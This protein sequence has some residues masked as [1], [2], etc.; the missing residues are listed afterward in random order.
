MSRRKINL[1]PKHHIPGELG[2]ANVKATHSPVRL[3]NPRKGYLSGIGFQSLP[4]TKEWGSSCLGGDTVP[5][6]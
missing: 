2:L 3:E 1:F 6:K 4:N 5:R